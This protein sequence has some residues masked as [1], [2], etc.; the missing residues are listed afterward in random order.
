[1]MTR[2]ETLADL[3][4]ALVKA[5]QDKG[6]RFYLW[7]DAATALD[8]A[9]DGK[10]VERIGPWVA[11][12]HGGYRDLCLAPVTPGTLYCPDHSHPDVITDPP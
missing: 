9:R 4:Q 8:F 3:E 12:R 5:E 10:C 1:M 11:D 6:R 2:P 7:V